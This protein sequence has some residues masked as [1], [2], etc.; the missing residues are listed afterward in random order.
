MGGLCFVRFAAS[1]DV[2]LKAIKPKEPS[3]SLGPAVK[4][5]W[6]FWPFN[7]EPPPNSIPQSP[8]IVMAVPA[9]FFT[10]PTSFPVVRLK[11][12]IV[13]VEVLFEISKVPLRVPKFAGAIAKPQGWFKGAPW[14]KC[15]RK[16]P[17]SPKMSM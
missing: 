15:F 16:V 5:S 6:F 12:L 11:P 3:V 7:A 2:Y 8:L 17:S 9:E 10:V 4:K 14:A 1:A 13:P